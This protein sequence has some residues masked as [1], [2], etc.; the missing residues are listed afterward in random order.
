MKKGAHLNI[1]AIKEQQLQTQKTS[2][3][4]DMKR[5]NYVY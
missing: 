3:Q 5:Y 1:Y 4:K 2:T